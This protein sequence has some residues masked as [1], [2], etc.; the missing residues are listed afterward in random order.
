[1]IMYTVGFLISRSRKLDAVASHTQRSQY[2]LTCKD[3]KDTL[4][5]LQTMTAPPNEA[6]A[7][8]HAKTKRTFNF[9]A[10]NDDSFDIKT[11]KKRTSETVGT[12]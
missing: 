8:E 11:Y 6:N 12:N 2:R 3:D 7:G 1:M 5:Q 10:P 9:N 4:L